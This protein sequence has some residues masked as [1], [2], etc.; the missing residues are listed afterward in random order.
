MEERTKDRRI[1][2][3]SRRVLFVFVLC[4]GDYVKVFSVVLLPC[5]IIKS[6]WER[7]RVLENE[8]SNYYS[9]NGKWKN[10]SALIF[11]PTTRLRLAETET[12]FP[13]SLQNFPHF[14]HMSRLPTHYHPSHE[15]SLLSPAHVCYVHR[16]R[17]GRDVCGREGQRSYLMRHYPSGRVWFLSLRDQATMTH[18]LGLWVSKYVT[19]NTID[20]RRTDHSTHWIMAW[21]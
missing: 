5:F 18:R 17:Q 11:T 10:T 16:R 21:Q 15:F 7:A 1:W 8:H 14:P 6:Q 2:A 9:P 19:N 4:L 20:S 12:A 13:P 3:F